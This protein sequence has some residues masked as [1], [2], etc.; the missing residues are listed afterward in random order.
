MAMTD[1]EYHSD[2][3]KWGD[4]Q[5]V[6]LSDIIN[7][8]MIINVGDDKLINDIS[9]FDVIFH[10]KR[11]LQEL[12]YDALKEVKS[13]ELEMPDILQVTLPKDYVSLVKISW[14]DERGILY[15]MS[16]GRLTTSVDKALLQDHR[17]E[18][19]FSAGVDGEVLEGTPLMDIRNLDLAQDED[20]KKNPLSEYSYGGRFGMDPTNANTNGT[21]NI[22]K[23]LGVIRF[24]SNVSGKLIVIEYISDGMVDTAE[25]Q[26]K[27]H[28]FA[29][30]FLYNYI[31][32]QVIKGKFGVQE[33]IVRRVKQDYFSSL[34]NTKVRLMD[35]HPL[36]LIQSLRGRNKWIK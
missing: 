31:L 24:D 22:N 17:G 18:L 8:F 10:A 2:S 20:D 34:K 23:S 36:D 11:G 35:I 15:P 30:D 25:S 6:N 21:Y 33:Y 1:Q 9:R 12:H 29:E 32:Y 3:S 7:N 26:M 27:V 28:K 13:I 5:Y 14:V 19:L 4:G 16:T